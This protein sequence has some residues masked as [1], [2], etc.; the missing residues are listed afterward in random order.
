MSECRR[1][2]STRFRTP[3]TLFQRL[4]RHGYYQ[5]SSR[6]SSKDALRQYE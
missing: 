6:V 3:T 2:N 4:F 5:Q 1:T